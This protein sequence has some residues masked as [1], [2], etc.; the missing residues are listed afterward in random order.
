MILVMLSLSIGMILTTAADT[1]AQVGT[2]ITFFSTRDGNGEIYV[3]N[4]DGTNQTNLS[5]NPATDADSLFSPD[6][7]KIAFRSDRDSNN[8]IYIMNADGTHQRQI[9]SGSRHEP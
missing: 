5:N 2:K 4:A 3:M 7:T 8:E 9:N 6:G 1:A